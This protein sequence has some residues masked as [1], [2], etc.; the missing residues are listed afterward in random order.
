MLSIPVR[1][2]ARCIAIVIRLTLFGDHLGGRYLDPEQ[3]FRQALPRIDAY[4]PAYS[5]VQCS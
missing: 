4:G 3:A 1:I 2:S 5:A